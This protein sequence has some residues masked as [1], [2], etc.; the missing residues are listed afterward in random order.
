MRYGVPALAGKT[1]A[2][3]WRVEPAKAGTPY[4]LRIARSVLLSF[5]F[6][7]LFPT[8]GADLGSAFDAANKMY[9][10]GNFQA[11]ANGYENLIR[12]GVKNPVVYFNL[13]NAWF[14]AGQFG[15]AI[16]AYREAQRLA[17]RDPNVRFNL[18]FV[19]KQVT[20]S[21][22]APGPVW[23]EWLNNLT[24]NEWTLAAVVTL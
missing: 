12:G 14:K 8:Q 13:G 7:S 24:L 17:P 16:A 10:Q 20:G 21:E 6:L 23:R 9:E 11:A 15:R 3:H 4:P 1:Q 18:Q 2:L 19:R 22:L 5:I